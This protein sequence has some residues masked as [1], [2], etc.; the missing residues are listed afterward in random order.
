M[1]GY[2]EL[3]A[4]LDLQ[5]GDRERAMRA[6]AALAS[7]QHSADTAARARLAIEAIQ[8]GKSVQDVEAIMKPDPQKAIQ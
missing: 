6:L 2:A 4:R 8:A 3:E 5:A 1:Q 7:N